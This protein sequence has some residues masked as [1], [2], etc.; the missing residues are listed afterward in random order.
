MKTIAHNCGLKI[1]SI[2]KKD[3][4]G[5][6]EFRHLDLETEWDVRFMKALSSELTF[7]KVRFDLTSKTLTIKNR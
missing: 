7:K 3:L 1:S 6:V 5:A 4:R 2:L